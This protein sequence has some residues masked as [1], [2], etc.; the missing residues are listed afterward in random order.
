MRFHY[1][2]GLDLNQLWVTA[3][4]LCA[5][6]LVTLTIGLEAGATP[7]VLVSDRASASVYRFR[8]EA[9]WRFMSVLR[10]RHPRLI[11]SAGC[12]KVA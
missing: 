12:G 9:C 10:N 8:V 3:V 7:V 4:A 6:V 2:A 11:D 5:I 1:V